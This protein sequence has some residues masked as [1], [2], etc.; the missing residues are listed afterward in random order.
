M[1]SKTKRTPQS[2]PL[3]SS[4]STEPTDQSRLASLIQ[5]KKECDKVALDLVLKLIEPGVTKE[6]LISNVIQIIYPLKSDFL[7]WLAK[8]N[9]IFIYLVPE[10]SASSLRGCDRGAS[11]KRSL[12][13]G[14]MWQQIGPKYN[15]EAAVCHQR[16]TS[17][18]HHQEKS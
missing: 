4:S 6:F 17:A 5:K 12:R 10:N 3:P 2:S 13:M 11:N 7:N 8:F 15:E 1:S 14:L 18:R 9:R 16:E